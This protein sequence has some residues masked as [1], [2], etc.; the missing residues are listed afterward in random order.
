M[1]NRGT[2]KAVRAW[3]AGYLDAHPRLDRVHRGFVSEWRAILIFALLLVLASN[4]F[5][6]I[7]E[8]FAIEAPF[9][10]IDLA[11]FDALQNLRRPRLDTVMVAITQLGDT[12]PVLIVMLA[13]AGWLI[14]MRAWRPLAFFIVAVGGGALLN[15][16][17]KLTLQ[18]AR[19]L[20]L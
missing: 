6:E 3:I 20:E 9:S 7:V 10:A 16:V 15:S 12:V 19:P 8:D 13:V 5:F 4:L 2:G 14:R 1:L 17:M 11:I 18:R